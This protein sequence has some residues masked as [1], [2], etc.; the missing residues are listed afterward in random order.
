MSAGITS[1]VLGRI[2]IWQDYSLD[3]PTILS[4]T[5]QMP[6]PIPEIA[7]NVMG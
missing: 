5:A 7:V 6:V 1:S 3:W 2:A 4:I